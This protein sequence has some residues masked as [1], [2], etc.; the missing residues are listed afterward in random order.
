MITLK[1]KGEERKVDYV[2]AIVLREMEAPLE[3]I[4]QYSEKKGRL[5]ARDMD[6]LVK[7]FCLFLN[8]QATP[9]EILQ[10]YPADRLVIDIFSA[11][12]HCQGGVTELLTAFPTPAPERERETGA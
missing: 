11:L 2:R 10:E 3:I 5:S 9:E 6:V 12:K 1:L 7:W 4:D 8:N